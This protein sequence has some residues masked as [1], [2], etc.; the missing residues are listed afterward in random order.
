MA[1]VEEEAL[2]V[3]SLKGKELLCFENFLYRVDKQQDKTRQHGVTSNVRSGIAAPVF[4]G[5]RTVVLKLDSVTTI[6]RI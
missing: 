1:E 2:F 5:S 6:V 4:G 3:K